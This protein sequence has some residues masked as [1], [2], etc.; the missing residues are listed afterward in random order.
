MIITVPSGETNPIHLGLMSRYT[1][2]LHPRE[3]GEAIPIEEVRT[4]FDGLGCDTHTCLGT[5][6]MHATMGCDMPH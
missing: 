1:Y 2:Y 3:H 5:L 4:V 6:A